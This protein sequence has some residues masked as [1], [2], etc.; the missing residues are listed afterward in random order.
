[1]TAAPATRPSN[2]QKANGVDLISY[3]DDSV[4]SLDVRLESGERIGV[5]LSKLSVLALAAALADWKEW[6][7]T[8]PTGRRSFS[9]R[10]AK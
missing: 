1:M 2:W 9:K 10:G 5:E 6:V 4:W 3:D 7:K 8:S